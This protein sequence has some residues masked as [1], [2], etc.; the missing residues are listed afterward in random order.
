LLASGFYVT[1][2]RKGSSYSPPSEQV[3]SVTA[4]DTTKKSEP[5]KPAASIDKSPEAAAAG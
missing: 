4:A 2:N 3:K 5:E 1:D